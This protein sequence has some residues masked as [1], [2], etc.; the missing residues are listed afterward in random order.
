L[1]NGSNLQQLM[2]D[3]DIMKMQ[4]NRELIA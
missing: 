3:E 4:I 1:D 2:T